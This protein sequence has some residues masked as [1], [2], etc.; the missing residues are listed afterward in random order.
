MNGN[1]AQ[2]AIGVDI[3]GTKVNMG[4]VDREGRILLQRTFPTQASLPGLMDRLISGLHAFIADIRAAGYAHSGIGVGTAGQIDPAT[5][6]VYASSDLIPGYAGTRIRDLLSGEFDCPVAVDN[7]VNVLAVAEKHFGA[8]KDEANVLCLA[9]GTGIGG[10]I[11]IDGELVHGAFGGAGEF[12]HL[13]VDMNGRACICGGRGCLEAYAS[14]TSIARLMAERLNEQGRPGGA[15]P[16]DAREVVAGWLAGDEDAEAVMDIVF[17]ALGAALASLVHAFNPGTIVIG[18]GVAD[19][20]RPF[21]DRLQVELE[22]RAMPSMG[23]HA[24]VCPSFLGNRS[25]M[26]GAAA[27]LWA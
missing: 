8:A 3:G 9:I 13:S 24:R 2:H 7:D 12:G 14:G 17:A 6:S 19:I 26:V 5:G 16:P 27:L 23:R 18:G 20:G 1:Q 15:S 25:A 21:F 4:L 11:L 22:R 10:A